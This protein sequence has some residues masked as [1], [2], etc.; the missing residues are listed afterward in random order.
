M[1]SLEIVVPM[2]GRGSRFAD[3]GYSVPKPLIDVLGRPMIERVV[4]NLRP[5]RLHR[6]TFIVQREHVDAFG[7]DETLERVAP[8]CRV[9][10]LDEVTEGA[11][12]TVLLAEPEWNPDA[13]LVIANS[14]QW[15]SGGLDPFLEAWDTSDD[16]GLIMTMTAD[17]PKWSFLEVDADGRVVRVVEKEVVSDE[18]T[19][20]IYAFRQARM[21]SKVSRAM[22]A[23]DDR[24]GGEFYVAP[25]YNYLAPGDTIGW[26]NIGSE[27]DGM[28]GLGTPA[29]LTLFINL[30]RAGRVTGFAL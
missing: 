14:D 2:A 29:D 27:A 20:G 30:V 1:T 3:A 6:F 28:Y 25:T 7:V 16:A 18:A 11:A 13:P 26:V 21:F 5:S 4:D 22:I 23:A 10:I 24:V 9:V 17:D 19:V 12:C 8:G 15:V